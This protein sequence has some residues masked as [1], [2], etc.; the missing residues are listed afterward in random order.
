M[1]KSERRWVLIENLCDFN[2]GMAIEGINDGERKSRKR[3]GWKVG[4]TAS[5][6]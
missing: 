6:I 1:R 5:W 4:K 2:K 3:E